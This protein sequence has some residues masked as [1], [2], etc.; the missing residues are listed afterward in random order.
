MPT[1]FYVFPMIGFLAANK[2]KTYQGRIIGRAKTLYGFL[3]KNGLAN[4]KLLMPDG[5]PSRTRDIR[6][7]DLTEEGQELMRR[8]LDRWFRRTDRTGDVVNVTIFEK[9]LKLMRDKRE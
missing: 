4:S 6:Y 9:E 1:D 8:C 7:S 5:E 2:S 3:E